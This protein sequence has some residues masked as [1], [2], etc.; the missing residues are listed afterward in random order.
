[1]EIVHCEFPISLPNLNFF[2]A[3][4]YEFPRRREVWCHSNDDNF[5]DEYYRKFK[6]FWLTGVSFGFCVDDTY[7]FSKVV[8]QQKENPHTFVAKEQTVGA[9]LLS[10]QFF[11]LAFLTGRTDDLG[12]FFFYSLP[13]VVNLDKVALN[14]FY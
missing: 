7:S 13:V 8:I 11:E 2:L 6:I 5:V 12:A 3:I 9:L 14:I 10:H 4:K 1:M